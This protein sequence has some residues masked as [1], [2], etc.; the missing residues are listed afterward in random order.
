MELI[1]DEFNKEQARKGVALPRDQAIAVVKD[2]LDNVNFADETLPD[3]VASTVVDALDTNDRTSLL[4]LGL[5]YVHVLQQLDDSNEISIIDY[6]MAA[7]RRYYEDQI[8]ASA[9][10]A[11]ETL[12]E[13]AI[14]EQAKE[15]VATP[16]E[17]QA[18][19]SAFTYEGMQA[20]GEPTEATGQGTRDR[21]L[22]DTGLLDLSTTVVDTATGETT[23][24]YTDQDYQDMFAFGTDWQQPME[25][26]LDAQQRGYFPTPGMQET[27]VFQPLTMFQWETATGL[28]EYAQNVPT[29]VMGLRNAVR[30]LPPEQVRVLVTK[31]NMAGIFE[32]LGGTPDRAFS[33]SDQ[34]IQ[35][36]LNL[37]MAESLAAGGIGLNEVLRR[38]TRERVN[39]V[40]K[41]INDANISTVQSTL[42]QIGVQFL[43]RPLTEEESLSVL[44]GL[45]QLAP[46]FAEAQLALGY[47]PQEI[48]EDVETI[49]EAEARSIGA[50][51]EERFKGQATRWRAGNRSRGLG[52]EFAKL[53]RGASQTVEQDMPLSGLQSSVET[54]SD[55]LG[56][57]NGTA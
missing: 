9:L 20:G 26:F 55:V 3:R 19:G 50:Q 29:G 31:M 46:E 49:T 4:L 21:Y 24:I 10:T 54:V 39:D 2:I 14:R 34:W 23:R 6:D 27:G 44:S 1:L 42:R 57:S 5:N 17:T 48:V 13:T 52:E 37:L 16:F 33:G 41:L 22:V 8:V 32:Q 45:E 43:G 28:P 11:D 36:G 38:R 40:R 51:I 15:Y 35:S 7:I 12:D 25:F 30:D 53:K 47:S 18:V 56:D